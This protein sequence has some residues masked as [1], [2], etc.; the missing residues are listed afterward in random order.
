MERV[1]GIKKY[2][3]DLTL[4]E[5]KEITSTFSSNPIPTFDEFCSHCQGRINLMPDIKRCPPSQLDQ[6]VADIEDIMKKYNLLKEALVIGDTEIVDKFY[7]KTKTAWRDSYKEAI[8]SEKAHNDPTK[9]FFIFNHGKH[10]N[11]EEV[12][13]FHKMGLKIIVSINN[14]HYPM[15]ILICNMD[16]TT[17][18]V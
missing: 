9:Y 18:S 5:L 7:G 14:W 13:G 15:M 2:L 12:D 6:Y 10:F 8:N 17:F 16:R 4:A 11:K 1:L 3:R